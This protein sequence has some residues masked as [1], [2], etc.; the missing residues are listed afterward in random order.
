LSLSEVT[1]GD[2]NVSGSG[3][4][5]YINTNG[6]AGQFIAGDVSFL[7]MNS[8]KGWEWC[9]ITID[10]QPLHWG[11]R[12]VSRIIETNQP[13]PFELFAPWQA[14]LQATAGGLK[15]YIEE[16]AA[17]WTAG[18]FA[19][20][21]ALGV[22]QRTCG[23]GPRGFYYGYGPTHQEEDTFAIDFTHTI[24]GR[25]WDNSSR[26]MVAAVPRVGIVAS[27]CGGNATG[28]RTGNFVEILHDDWPRHSGTNRYLSRYL[29]LDGPSL[30]GGPSRLL[31]S[32]GMLVLEGTPIGPVDNTG[33]SALD[34]LHFS[35]HDQ[36]RPFL[37]AGT[38]ERLP[39]MPG[40][41]CSR[42]RRGAS[43]RPTPMSGHRL[44]DGDEGTCIASDTRP[45]LVL[46]QGGY[47]T[48]PQVIVVRRRVTGTVRP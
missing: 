26:R 36:T 25:P 16:N 47:G 9:G 29:H 3:V 22:S 39:R 1:L 45:G 13:L 2:P 46:Y 14:P 35:I 18:P 15:R 11:E 33:N 44:R 5:F 34:H 21:I 8:P 23:F 30:P 48:A 38:P 27:V 42:L 43:V 24:E 17:I 7:L 10:P 4:R 12:W 28:S 31:V 19:P 32:A 20:L 37:G 40:G 6:W 41:A